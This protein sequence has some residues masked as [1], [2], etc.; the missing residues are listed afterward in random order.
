M[1]KS[2]LIELYFSLEKAEMHK[3]E[4]FIASPY[5]NKNLHILALFSHLKKIYRKEGVYEINKESVWKTVFP[6]EVYN[7]KKMRELVSKGIMLI[8]DYLY[9]NNIKTNRIH[10]YDTLLTV[11]NRN[12][13]EKS[14]TTHLNRLEKFFKEK[15][16][17]DMLYYHE[18]IQLLLQKNN[19]LIV[20]PEKNIV[21]LLN[22]LSILKDHI[23]I[24]NYLLIL[25]Y[26]HIAK[27]LSSSLKL[28]EIVYE[29]LLNE[30]NIF[31]KE[32]R[33]EVMDKHPLLYSFYLILMAYD[34]SEDTK[35]YFTLKGFTMNKLKEFSNEQKGYLYYNLHNY[36]MVRLS[37][38][39]GDFKKEAFDTIVYFEKNSNI[40]DDENF[41]Y[42]DFLN[43]V[44][45]GIEREELNWVE[46]FIQKYKEKIVYQYRK[47]TYCYAMSLVQ[48]SKKEFDKALENLNQVEF[49][50]YYFY[51]N[52]KTLQIKVYFEIK[53]VEGILSIIDSNRHFFKKKLHLPEYL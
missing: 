49:H 17:V 5:F 18:Y 12:N 10:Y 52:A 42:L 23:G 41:G 7:D 38:G 37:K 29:K 4:D 44:K 46:K 3:F 53:E 25:N 8:E 36:A 14:Y 32:N 16:N 33:K 51:L 39:D 19:H 50:D 6:D 40:F 35:H 1:I 9:F 26:V 15:N 30:V 45:L 43:I 28:D 20:N 31:I 34:N 2:R 27:S 48:F 22:N 47:S 21:E 13:L 11:F 24:Y